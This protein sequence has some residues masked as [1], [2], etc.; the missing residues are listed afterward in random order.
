MN[1]SPH[2]NLEEF[3]CS[4]TAARHGI[5][6]TPGEKEIANLRRLVETL[7]QVRDLLGKPIVVSSGFRCLAVNS[8]VGSK[9]TSQHVLGCAADIKVPGMTPDQVVRSIIVSNIEFDQCIKEF[10]STGGGWTHISV[11][12]TSDTKARK[13]ALVIDQQGTRIFA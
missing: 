6:N 3:V 8:L 13:M 10:A 12:N 11:P 5:D 4:E 7:E 1:L 9:P 2:F